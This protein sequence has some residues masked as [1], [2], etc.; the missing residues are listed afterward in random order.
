MKKKYYPDWPKNNKFENVLEKIDDTIQ[1][2][3]N[4]LNWLYF[5]RIE[6]N[7]H[8]KI[9]DHDTW[10]MDTTLAYIILPMLKQLQATKHSAPYVDPEDVPQGLRPTGQMKNNIIDNTHFNRWDYVL[11]EMIWTF[12]QK[13]LDDWEDQYWI[14]RPVFNF[15]GPEDEEGNVEVKQIKHGKCDWDRKKKHQ[16]RMTNG[17]RLFGKYYENLWD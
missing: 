4:I 5:D 1:S 15:D 12:E 17:F 8:I 11:Q 6:R 13:C 14:E 2:L 16:E 9:H 7:V 10:N 3:Y